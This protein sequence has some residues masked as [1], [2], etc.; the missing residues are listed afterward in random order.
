MRMGST[1]VQS[2]W[3]HDGDEDDEVG[4]GRLGRDEYGMG[5]YDR[6]EVWMSGK[7]SCDWGTAISDSEGQQ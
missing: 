2:V 4:C 5:G 3:I 6:N 7:R 1:I